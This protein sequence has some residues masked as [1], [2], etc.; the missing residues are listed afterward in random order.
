[1]IYFLLQPSSIKKL[2]ELSCC[3]IAIFFGARLQ[4]ASLIRL[5]KITAVIF[6][7][8]ALKQ[9]HL[10]NSD[11]GRIISKASNKRAFTCR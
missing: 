9:N 4:K 2:I 3:E 7:L 1:M 5:S 10:C 11:T 8:E 6:S